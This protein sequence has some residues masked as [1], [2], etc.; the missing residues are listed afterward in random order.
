MSAVSVQSRREKERTGNAP[1]MIADEREAEGIGGREKNIVVD[2]VLVDES[3]R[4][5]G[6]GGGNA[7]TQ[8]ETKTKRR[9]EGQAST[10][11]F[12]NSG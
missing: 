7:K 1:R 12:I 8:K 11:G 4:G 10:S 3:E 5:G 6:N 9:T 2:D